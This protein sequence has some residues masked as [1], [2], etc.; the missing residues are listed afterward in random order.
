[1]QK[2]T[3]TI[4]VGDYF[5]WHNSGWWGCQKVIYVGKNFVL[6]RNKAD[7]HYMA[8]DS[9][10]IG[11]ADNWDELCVVWEYNARKP[12]LLHSEDIPIMSEEAI[13]AK[14]LL[15][16]AGLDAIGRKK[17]PRHKRVKTIEQKKIAKVISKAY[18]NTR[19]QSSSDFAYDVKRHG[20]KVSDVFIRK[21]SR[22]WWIGF[23]LD[24][25]D[26]LY[27]PGNA[28]EDYINKHGPKTIA[29]ELFDFMANNNYYPLLKI[30][31]KES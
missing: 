9:I 13:E 27:R 20:I 22:E 30:L 16:L 7:Y 3:A 23:T 21:I 10:R 12:V 19:I 5:V 17:V 31:R 18:Q 15:A 14:R 6:Y 4:K 25:I 2:H 28:I 24:G 26:Q 11:K 1:M 8:F 29:L